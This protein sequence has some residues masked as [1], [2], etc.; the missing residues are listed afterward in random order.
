MERLTFPLPHGF[1][2]HS[3]FGQMVSGWAEMGWA[4]SKLCPHLA[5]AYS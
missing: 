1:F 3:S 2:A 5:Q 4:K